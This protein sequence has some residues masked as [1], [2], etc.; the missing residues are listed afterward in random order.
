MDE[1]CR[2][3]P[4]NKLRTVDLD[5]HRA[6]VHIPQVSWLYL[7]GRPSWKCSFILGE[8]RA[9]SQEPRA[10]KAGIQYHHKQITVE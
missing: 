2:L 9:K 4:I 3:H 10:K 8:P 7:G 5:C 1:P 6:Y